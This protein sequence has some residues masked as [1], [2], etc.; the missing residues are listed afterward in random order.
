MHMYLSLVAKDLGA[1]ELLYYLMQKSLSFY[2][3]LWNMV[4][5]MRCMF[6]CSNLNN[7]V[8]ELSFYFHLLGF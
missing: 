4:V 5:L 1:I 6:L 2:Y 8:E 7:M 3:L